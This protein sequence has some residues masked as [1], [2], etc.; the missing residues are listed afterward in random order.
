MLTVGDPLQKSPTVTTLA[1]TG[2][3]GYRR[4]A[5]VDD[6]LVGYLSLGDAQPDSL[7]IKWLIDKG[8]PV[9]AITKALLKGN[10]DVRKYLSRKSEHFGQTEVLTTSASVP[11]IESRPSTASLQSQQPMRIGNDTEQLLLPKVVLPSSGAK[12][13]RS[14]WAYVEQVF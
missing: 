10:I 12:P 6:R 1:S 3:N 13:R 4:L 9:R 8:Y 11:C 5:I 7:A 2:K 14:L